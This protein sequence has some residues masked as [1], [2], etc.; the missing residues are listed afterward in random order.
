MESGL[1]PANKKLISVF[2]VPGIT[3]FCFAML[4]PI[5]LALYYSFFDW[6]SISKPMWSGLKN[7]SRLVGDKLF[8]FSLYNN[9]KLAVYT[10]VGQVGIGYLLAILLKSKMI[11]LGKFHRTV[12]FFPV[13]IG[14]V[15]L[16]FLWMLVYSDDFGIINNFL[17]MVGLGRF[18]TVWLSNPKVVV[19]A[20][21]VPLIWQWFG[22][23]MVIFMGA[24][25]TIPNEVL[26]SAE[27]DGANGI[28]RILYIFIPLTYDTLKVTVI[29]CL[30]GIMKMFDHVLVMTGGGPGDSSMVLALYAYKTSFNNFELGYGNTISVGI[31][32]MSLTITLLAKKLMGGKRYE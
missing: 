10:L 22:F 13:V 15:V 17:R 26:E 7:Y 27:I 25:E 8:W 30:G 1:K 4:A 18:A 12:M 5:F 3:L 20:L 19:E 32:L 16:S 21:A 23:Y 9:L 6:E 28:R 29:L 31:L 2:I 24:I 11:R 14:T